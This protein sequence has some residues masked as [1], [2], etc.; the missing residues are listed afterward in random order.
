MLQQFFC[1]ELKT[2]SGPTDQ[3]EE[4]NFD[5]IDDEEIERVKI[6][7]SIYLKRAKIYSTIDDLR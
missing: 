5:D 7:K 2:E 4:S 1:S 6:L 3:N